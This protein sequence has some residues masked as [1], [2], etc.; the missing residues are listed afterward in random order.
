MDPKLKKQLVTMRLYP[1]TIA[2]IES[3][4]TGRGVTQKFIESAILEKL[5]RLNQEKAKE[6]EPK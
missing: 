2:A 4:G 5:E 1:C 3:H 6:S